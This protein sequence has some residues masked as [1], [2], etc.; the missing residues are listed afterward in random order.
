MGRKFD[1]VNE[2]MKIVPYRVVRASNGDARINAL[3]KNA[4]P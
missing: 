1:E 4:R 3:G 2:E